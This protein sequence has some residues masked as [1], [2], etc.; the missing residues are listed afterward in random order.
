MIFELHYFA[1]EMN[2]NDA[3]ATC[4]EVLGGH[5]VTVHSE[6]DRRAVLNFVATQDPTMPKFWIG[7]SDIATEVPHYMFLGVDCCLAL[8][9][10]QSLF[11]TKR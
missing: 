8:H 9:A 4:D 6:A 7:L 11:S 3:E 5:L 1:L 2:W 10:R